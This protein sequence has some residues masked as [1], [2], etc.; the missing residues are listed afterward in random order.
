MRNTLLVTPWVA[1]TL[2]SA[3][4]LAGCSGAEGTQEP[5]DSDIASEEE[6]GPVAPEV[7]V[8]E[9]DGDLLAEVALSETHRV[10]FWETGPGEL[11]LWQ[12]S[13]MDLDADAMDK[14]PRFDIEAGSALEYYRT[15]AGAEIDAEVETR[16]AAFDERLTAARALQAERLAAM[17]EPEHSSVDRTADVRDVTPAAPLALK[18]FDYVADGKQWE[19]INCW[20][21]W[22]GSDTG[23][24]CFSN[25]TGS[26][27]SSWKV[28]HNYLI[29]AGNSEFASVNSSTV[30]INVAYD[31]CYHENWW[32]ALT[33]LC[34]KLPRSIGSANIPNR[35][36]VQADWTVQSK[37]KVFMDGWRW[38]IFEAWD[39]R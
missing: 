2:M 25:A 39:D 33:T 27:S 1:A 9:V 35:T 5:T 12:T 22:T 14:T 30:S 11:M 15:L 3:S 19:S 38:P 32:T 21:R 18:A 16:L 31:P 26:W 13:H 37:Y 10:Q 8:I 20:S 7:A 28:A 29:R 34:T 24:F 23:R 4:M 36:N 17:P 6:Q